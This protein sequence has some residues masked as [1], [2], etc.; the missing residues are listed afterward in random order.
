ML[1]EADP[2]SLCSDLPEEKMTPVM[3]HLSGV[4]FGTSRLDIFSPSTLTRPSLSGS[5]PRVLPQ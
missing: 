5:Q 4:N 2:R 3:H 1:T